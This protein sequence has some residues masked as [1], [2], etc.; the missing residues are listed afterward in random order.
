MRA[1]SNDLTNRR[2]LADSGGKLQIALILFALPV[3]MVLIGLQTKKAGG[4]YWQGNIDPSYIYLMDGL[5]V[6]NLHRPRQNEHPGTPVQ[7]YTGALIR[8]LNLSSNEQVTAT[9]VIA[10][11]E[12]Y[13][14]FTNYT[15]IAFYALCMFAVGW[16]AF[17]VT[18]SR[19]SSLLAQAA[20]FLSLTIL[21]G[22]VGVRP[23]IFFLCISMLLS[24][25]ILLSFKFSIAR[26][27]LRFVLAFGLLIG[28]GIAS[29]IT[30][31]PLVVIPFILLPSWKWRFTFTLATI[32]SFLISI[33]PIITP[34][35]L[36]TLGHF[37]FATATHTGTYGYGA[38]GIVDAHN[39]LPNLLAL[40]RGDLISFIFIFGGVV[41]LVLRSKIPGL[42]SPRSRA[43]LAVTAAQFCLLVVVAKHPANRYLIPALGLIGINF[44]LVFETVAQKVATTNPRLYYVPLI[45]VCSL[46]I[47]KRTQSL[48]TLYGSLGRG[49]REI[50][51]VNAILEKESREAT[52]VHY[53]G[54][55]SV[56]YGLKLGSEYS[57]N[58]YAPL[59]VKVYPRIYFYDL[60][61]LEFSDFAGPVDLD[62]IKGQKDWWI[63]HGFSLNEPK[64]RAQVP[65]KVLP[66]D[67]RIDDIHFGN[68]DDPNV[69]NGETVYRAFRVT[70]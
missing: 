45:L 28:V 20:P 63:M 41:L 53:L 61:K 10:N 3:L 66:D 39:Y 15:L 57:G 58:I 30:F 49:V 34:T 25:V 36:H 5:N 21:L 22:L 44:M 50:E 67:I 54:A 55:S 18:G 2:R 47:F 29:K 70:K 42:D 27:A 56:A 37:I 17:L 32:V 33:A 43:L 8:L 1:H 62:Q 65:D 11:P 64:F 24:G 9:K 59:L 60:W 7:V 40:I 16:I 31:A 46:L 13:L 38:K 69:W 48:H 26:Y 52:V 35:Q 12:F 6:A 19:L 4:E 68:T 51:T 14:S 23:E